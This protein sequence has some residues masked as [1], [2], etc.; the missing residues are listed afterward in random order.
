[1][2]DFLSVTFVPIMAGLGVV[3]GAYAT[4]VALNTYAKLTNTAATTAESGARVGLLAG[5]AAQI[6]AT[7]MAAAAALGLSAPVLG[8][9]L[10]VA[11]VVALFVGL[12]RT[13]FT[14]DSALDAIG[15]NLKRFGMTLMELGVG[16]L[17]L[18]NK[19][20]FGAFGISEEQEKNAMEKIAADRKA[21]DDREQ[22]RDKN[23]E[24]VKKE[25]GIATEKEKN[26]R[27]SNAVDAKIIADKKAAEDAKNKL[28]TNAGP[29][30]LLKQF[31]VKEG[32]SL[33]PKDKEPATAKAEVTKKEIEQKGEEKTAAMKKAVEEQAKAEEKTREEN[34]KEGKGAAPAQESAESLL[35]SLNTKMAELIK[36]NKGTQAVSEQQL[37]VQRGMTS[38]LFAA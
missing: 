31:A 9:V 27:K 14:V 34:K 21:L 25:R 38:D 3:L 11:A 32:S 17:R 16:F 29:E 4:S 30:A 15:D 12:Y 24:E 22:A 10:A 35:A 20:S 5:L 28:D 18:L 37:S 36:I 7:Y 1:V 2:G 26:G 33:I 6:K 13:G 8:L 19:V 23:R